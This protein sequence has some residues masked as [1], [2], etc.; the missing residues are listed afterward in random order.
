MV[1]SYAL[2]L[3]ADRQ[4]FNVRAAGGHSV[5]MTGLHPAEL[6]SRSL[7]DLFSPAQMEEIRRSLSE[8]FPA[9]VAMP[10]GHGFGSDSHQVIV[11]TLTDEIVLEVEPRRT[12]PHTGDYAARM[13][14]FSHEL[15]QQQSKEE[16]LDELCRGLVYHFGYDRA[17]VIQYDDKRDGVV[18]NEARSEQRSSMLGVR[19][20]EADI[21]EV[22]RRGQMLESVLNYTTHDGPL[23]E[24]VGEVSDSARE[25]LRYH[26]ASREP[27]ANT[28]EFLR[29]TDLRTLGSL[30]LTV[31]GQ[32]WGSVFLHSHEPLFLDYQM[33]AFLRVMGRVAQQKIGYHLYHNSLR[34]SSAQNRVRDNL[35][36]E[37]LR[38]PTL[39]YGL[40]E[41]ATTVLDLLASA[42]G[43][44][45]CGDGELTLL[46]R[47]P[48]NRQVNEV[49]RWIKETV[50]N[51]E[52]WITD[53]LPGRYEPANQIEKFPAG[54]LFVPLSPLAEQWIIWF[55]PET[56]QVRTYGSRM[57]P[58]ESK[59]GREFVMREEICR[60]CSLPWTD[61]EL[62]TVQA[63][64]FFIQTMVAERYAESRRANKLLRKAI[65]DLEI[66]SY[67]IS[68]DLRT[69]LRGIA[70]YAEALREDYA[71]ALGREGT[72]QLMVI[73]QSA[74]RMRAFMDDLLA[75]SRADRTNLVINCYAVSDIVDQVLNDL[76]TV[77]YE[78]TRCRVQENLPEICGDFNQMVVVFTNL[79]SN[80][81]KYSSE[82]EDRSIEVG[83]TGEDR[84]NS[85][86]FYIEDHGIGMPQAEQKRVFDL[87]ARLS[88]SQ[89]FKGTGIGLA[90]VHRIIIHHGGDVWIESES[91]QGTR[92]LF[93][94]GALPNEV[95]PVALSI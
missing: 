57:A 49:Y 61:D 7:R 75:L 55:K 35:Y 26:I 92:I 12:W 93:Y 63:L 69:P 84:N 52:I 78:V 29:Q 16:L 38:A 1:Q 85:P 18:T 31:D 45:I 60:H 4:T 13:N 42:D 32:L 41:G 83:Y 46:G 37:L 33:R 82:A 25:A 28:D 65:E 23:P 14:D 68:H 27:L 24:M 70:G 59:A 64:Q 95:P 20:V 77:P 8:D 79:L 80:A 40:T 5:E 10:E 47:T 56:V 58:P 54:L 48:T 39:V 62:G 66:F 15:E 67:T 81:F 34:M 9:V 72:D 19:Y 51:R 76:A 50:G 87:F 6:C 44:A 43:A 88:N 36:E 90:L 17:I 53:N 11:Y 74:D 86:V 94:T 73:E 30:S 2:V 3:V 89:N 22:S 71:A 91:G 21:P